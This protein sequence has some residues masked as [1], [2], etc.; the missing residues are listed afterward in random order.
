MIS[1]AMLSAPA[2]SPCSTTVAFGYLSTCRRPRS[3]HHPHQI[4]TKFTT[5]Y[6]NVLAIPLIF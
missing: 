5:I 4:Y 3:P 2:T 1:L 6:S